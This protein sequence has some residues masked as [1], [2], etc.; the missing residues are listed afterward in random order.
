MITPFPHQRLAID[1]TMDWFRANPTGNPVI[2]APPGSGKSVILSL[3]TA[4][5]IQTWPATRVLMLTHVKELIEQDSRALLRVWPEA[6]LG[7]YSAGLRRKDI[8]EPII[9]AGIQSVWNKAYQLGHRDLI[10]I[11]EV[12]LVNHKDTGIYRAFLNESKRINPRVRI[13]GLS[14]TPFR[15]GHGSIIEGED[16]LFHAISYEIGLLELIDQGYLAPPITKATSTQIDVSGVQIRQGEYAAGQLERAANVSTV[17]EAA[18]DEIEVYGQ[19]RKKWLVFCTGVHH[20]ENVA[21]A[22]R[23]RGL[24]VGCITGKTP[25]A[26][27]DTLIKQYRSGPLRALTSVG[28]LSTGFDAPETDLLACL[29]PTCSPGLWLQMVG[30][31]LRVAPEKENCIVLDFA[32]NTLRHGPVDQIKAWSPKPKDTDAQAPVKTCPECKTIVA[33]A[34]RECPT[35]GYEFSFDEHP[36]HEAKASD[37]PLLSRDIAPRLEQHPVSAVHY[38][39]HN[40]RHG[41]PPTLRTDYYD[42]FSRIASEWICFSHEGYARTKAIAWWAKRAPGTPIPRDVTEAHARQNELMPPAAIIIDTR[43]KY[44]EIK[45]HVFEQQ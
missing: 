5:A 35:C 40:S 14:A 41:G 21:E 4:E 19:N 20:A 29:R 37:A 8:Y 18:L 11:D 7:I 28:V 24:Q 27:R 33:T 26:E 3:L 17:T 42:A 38:H 15:T 16:A 13:I 2:V 25:S 12:H 44:P 32:N 22:M 36:K 43:P 45:Q 39:V 34:V 30:R 23:A 1:G 31:G 10:L 6:P 9:F